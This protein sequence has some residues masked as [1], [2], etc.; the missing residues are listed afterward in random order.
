MVQK[1]P[2]PQASDWKNKNYSRDFTLG[3][4][5]H[6]FPEKASWPTP[7]TAGLCGGTGNWEQL[8]KAAESVEE[9]RKMGAGNGG[10]LNAE[11]VEWLMGYPKEYT[12][13]NKNFTAAD[14]EPEFPWEAEWPDTPRITVKQPDRANR[15]KC[16][17]NA[18]VPQIAMMI[19]QRIK[20]CEGRE[21]NI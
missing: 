19:W 5:K 6:I 18:I 14:T 21:N 11:F 4:I 9:A 1:F 12:N 7:R 17:G 3:N 15:L 8:K 20:E 13:S 10:Q 2:T 16:L